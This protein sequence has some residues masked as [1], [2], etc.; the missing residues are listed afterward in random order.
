MKRPFQTGDSIAR[1]HAERA[2]RIALALCAGRSPE[3]VA[4][5]IA[6]RVI[7]SLRSKASNP[8]RP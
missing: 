6:S 7:R 1:F 3:Q 5:E 2:A 4:A 8:S